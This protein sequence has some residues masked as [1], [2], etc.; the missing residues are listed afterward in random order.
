[1]KNSQIELSIII[2]V[3]NVEKYVGKC[4]ESIFSQLTS[5][6]NEV[7]VIVV[8]DGTPDNSMTIVNGYRKYNNLRIINQENQGLSAAR[9]AG[10]K[11]ANGDY[12]WFVDSDDMIAE[13][14]LQYVLEAIDTH[15]GN[16]CIATVL[17]QKKE[18]DGTCSIEFTP[19]KDYK[20]SRDYLFDRYNIG[21]CQ[22]YILRRQFLI[23]NDLWYMEGVYHEDGDFSHRML[24]KAQSF[25]MLQ[26]S[27]YIYLLRDSGSI[28]SSRKPKKNYDLVK[29][30]KRLD[31]FCN[32]EVRREDYWKFKA[33]I[34]NCLKDTILFSRK[35]LFTDDFK[36]FYRGNKRL[37]RQEA[38]KL[39]RHCDKI[40]TR[41]TIEA[42]HFYIAPLFYTKFKYVVKCVLMKIHILK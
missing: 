34:F 10:L 9:N 37:L 15:K 40:G 25:L 41:K 18:S 17:L 1:M 32:D 38:L 19:K 21:A 16:D 5:L 4:L 24:Y 13:G 20:T 14:G 2:P 12:V 27:V 39:I 26:Q 31:K 30:Y 23:D 22:R 42:L 29:I 8:N 28:M 36:T 11:I 7:E 33:R 6:Q 35:E 3:Y